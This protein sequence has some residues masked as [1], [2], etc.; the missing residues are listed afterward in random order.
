MEAGSGLT[1]NSESLL[2]YNPKLADVSHHTRV[3][4]AKFMTTKIKKEIRFEDEKVTVE[5]EK[6]RERGLRAF[7]KFKTNAGILKKLDVA[8]TSS[9]AEPA[10]PPAS[11]IPEEDP[12]DF[13]SRT[14]ILEDPNEDIQTPD[15]PSTPENIIDEPVPRISSASPML[16]SS[17]APKLSPSPSPTPQITPPSPGTSESSRKPDSPMVKARSMS[18]TSEQSVKSLE[19]PKIKTPELSKTDEGNES[20]EDE[21]PDTKRKSSTS[22]T[23]L[24]VPSPAPNRPV[25]PTMSINSGDKGK[26]KISG[27]TLT[28]W[29]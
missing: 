2:E 21:K 17:P 14:P 18:I 16:T 1:M 19:P 12:N 7:N 20:D 9:G 5:N 22:S 11:P 23:H 6:E 3:A 28:G 27:K 25:S 29:I 10:A 15:R 13:R 26:S 8:G 24:N 4:Y